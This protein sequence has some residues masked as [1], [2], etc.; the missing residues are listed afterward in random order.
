MTEKTQTERLPKRAKRL[1]HF[2]NCKG[3]G[4]LVKVQHREDAPE[5]CAHCPEDRGAREMPELPEEAFPV[6]NPIG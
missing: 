1:P 4:T 5:A 3:C 2:V 6:P